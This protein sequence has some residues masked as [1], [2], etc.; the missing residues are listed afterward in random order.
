[1]NSSKRGGAYGFKLQSLDIIRETRAPSDRS[2][3]LLHFIASAMR[4]KYPHLLSFVSELQYLE[5]AATVSLDLLSADLRQITREMKEATAELINNRQNKT[6]KKFC[7]Q[8]EPRVTKLE[9]D[10][11]TA[12]EAFTEVVQYFGENSKQSQPN[13]V[14]SVLQRFVDGFRK[15]DGENLA[16]MTLRRAVSLLAGMN[17]DH[18]LD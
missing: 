16:R 15:V 14:F 10:F 13:T 1:M 12:K 17:V 5:K 8:A 2:M 7:L 11:Q 4:E 6:L 18:D 3:T 9:T